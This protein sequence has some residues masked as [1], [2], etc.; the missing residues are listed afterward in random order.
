[1]LFRTRQAGSRDVITPSRRYKRKNF[2][3]KSHLAFRLLR[4]RHT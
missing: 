3:A 4:R 1:M 2:N